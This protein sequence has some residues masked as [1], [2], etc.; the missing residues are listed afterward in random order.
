[1]KRYFRQKLT[2]LSAEDQMSYCEIQLHSFEKS[3]GR[4]PEE[5]RV[6]YAKALYSALKWANSV[7][8]DRIRK[9]AEE[10]RRKEMEEKKMAE[11][12]ARRQYASRREAF[13]DL[14][15]ESE[16][17]RPYSRYNQPSK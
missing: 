1:M 8:P 12:A 9:E 16:I 2:M 6:R 7:D 15:P 14:L 13:A 11:P 3:F 17:K 4:L 5:D 10:R